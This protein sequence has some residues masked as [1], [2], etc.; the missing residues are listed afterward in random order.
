MIRFPFVATVRH[1]ALQRRGNSRCGSACTRRRNCFSGTN[2]FSQ[3]KLVET[4]IITAKKTKAPN[5]TKKEKVRAPRAELNVAHQHVGIAQANL[6]V[7][8][9]SENTVGARRNKGFPHET[10]DSPK[11]REQSGRPKDMSTLWFGLHGAPASKRS[12]TSRV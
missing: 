6:A 11:H 7:S 3:V 8:R 5:V 2:R 1:D 4:F 12:E 10:G 9:K